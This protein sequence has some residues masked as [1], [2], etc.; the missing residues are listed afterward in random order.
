MIR[1]VIKIDEDL[2]DGCGKCIPGCHEGALQLIDGKARLVSELMCDGLGA[3]IGHCP[4]GA[5]SIERREAEPY[6]ETFVMKK[7]IEKGANTVIAHMKHLREHNE[8]ELLEEARKYLVDNSALVDFDSAKVI[9][10][11]YDTVP[12]S[13][14]FPTAGGCPGT[15]SKDLSGLHAVP[16]TGT[17]IP[18][19]SELSH[20]PVQMHLINPAASHYRDAD[21]LL[22]ADCVAYTVANFHGNYLK[23][24]KLAIACPKLDHGTD[25]YIDKIRRLI[26]EAMIRSLHLVVMEVP[27][28]IGLRRMVDIAREQARR[29]IH[30]DLSIVSI[31]GEVINSTSK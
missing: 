20:W 17:N 2:C 5:I 9:S 13:S 16:V 28:C 12:S 31:R 21:L 10:E 3:C 23:G 11:V 8:N 6:K 26:D 15:M 4:R 19:R 29:T 30:V 27:C 25:I 7:M 24:R 18:L 1:E 14:S 22:A